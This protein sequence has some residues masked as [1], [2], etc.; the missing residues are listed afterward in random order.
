MRLGILC[1]FSTEAE[2][3]LKTNKDSP[4][5]LNMAQKERLK[6]GNNP[7]SVCL[8]RARCCVPTLWGQYGFSKLH[9]CTTTN[10]TVPATPPQTSSLHPLR[11]FILMAQMPCHAR[12]VQLTLMLMVMMMMMIAEPLFGTHSSGSLYC[13]DLV[14][15]Q[16]SILFSPRSCSG[17][18][19]TFLSFKFEINL[20]K[21]CSFFA[22]F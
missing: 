16:L 5:W 3:L 20:I 2:R 18:K 21:T 17:D 14:H 7:S 10:P 6:R 11:S 13:K 15:Y 19:N 12:M 4:W 8:H 22:S 9:K 1:N